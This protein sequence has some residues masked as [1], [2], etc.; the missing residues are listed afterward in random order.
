MSSVPFGSC[1]LRTGKLPA[2]R[3][4]LPGGLGAAIRSTV[5]LH[6]V[7]LLLSPLITFTDVCVS[8]M[9]GL[10]S[11]QAPGILGREGLAERI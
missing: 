7:F 2:Y 5:T 11:N 4:P 9:P 8:S 1:R 3:L 10:S 6:S